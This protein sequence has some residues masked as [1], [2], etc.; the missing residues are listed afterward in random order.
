MTSAGLGSFLSGYCFILAN[1]K[2]LHYFFR[3]GKDKS[4]FISNM[5]WK[6]KLISSYILADIVKVS[7]FLP[8]EARK[9]RIQ[10]YHLI[11]EIGVKNYSNYMMR[12]FFPMILR[13]AIFRIITLGAFLKKLNVHHQPTLKYKLNDIKE[14]IR[15]KEKS[16][17]KVNVS[18]FMDYSRFHIYSPFPTILLNLVFCSV[19]ATIITQPID[20]IITKILTQTRL[21]YRGLISSYFIIV[22][23]EG[24]KKLFLSGLSPRI[25]FNTLS[26]MTVFLMYENINSKIRDFYEHDTVHDSNYNYNSYYNEK[27]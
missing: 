23:E 6:A 13:D 27:I 24:L 4:S 15:T 21:K 11:N 26:A 3:K 8:F 7:V 10:L 5:D 2:F 12:A 22:K 18:Y 17:Q 16:G 20:V 9:Q 1:E 25:S 14:Y 19:F